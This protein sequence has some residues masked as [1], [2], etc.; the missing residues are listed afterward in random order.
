MRSP[1]SSSARST[2]PG[3]EATPRSHPSMLLQSLSAPPLPPLMFLGELASSSSLTT[4]PPTLSSA[5]PLRSASMWAIKIGTLKGK[6]GEEVSLTDAIFI[7]TTSECSNLKDA[8][9]IN[10]VVTMKLCA[11]DAS[12]S[13]DAKRKS[14]GAYQR[15][16]EKRST[17][18][19][20][21]LK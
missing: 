15:S 5:E 21:I 2:W 19:I 13:S 1:R 4:Q 10:N 6:L 11:H 20:S 3:G 16:R 7:L 12:S 14:E 17:V 8:N 9:D 18:L